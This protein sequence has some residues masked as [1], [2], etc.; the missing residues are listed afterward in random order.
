M[1]Q[2]IPSAD[3]PQGPI[4]SQARRFQGSGP[5]TNVFRVMELHLIG[6]HR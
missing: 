2:L 3:T 6:G 1:L 5:P 4:K